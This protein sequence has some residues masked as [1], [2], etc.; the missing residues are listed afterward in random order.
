MPNKIPTAHHQQQHDQQRGHEHQQGQ[1]DVV[2]H[3]GWRRAAGSGRRG[4]GAVG[5]SGASAAGAG[6]G[7]APGRHGRW[8]PPG[9]APRRRGGAGRRAGGHRGRRPTHRPSRS[10]PRSA[11]GRRNAGRSYPLIVPGNRGRGARR[12]RRRPD[13]LPWRTPP[14]CG[15]QRG[16]TLERAAATRPSPSPARGSLGLHGPQITSP[17]GSRGASPPQTPSPCGSSSANAPTARCLRRAGA[18][19]S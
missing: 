4:N 7:G 10:G 8:A 9:S 18:A 15:W 2:P 12:P 1:P 6:R 19:G 3:L 16:R 11:G 17:G 13:M 5:T 14:A